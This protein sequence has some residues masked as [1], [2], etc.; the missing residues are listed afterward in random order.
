[1]GPLFQ[2]SFRDQFLRLR[3]GDRFWY[4]REGQLLPGELEELTADNTNFYKMVMRNTLNITSFPT[5]PF[6]VQRLTVADP[7]TGK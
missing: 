7:A 1:L 3:D 6:R 5:K 4:Q 2:A